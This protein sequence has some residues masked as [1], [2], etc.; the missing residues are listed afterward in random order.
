[1]QNFCSEN[2]KEIDH[3]GDLRVDGGTLFKGVDRIKLA[4][5]EVH[6]LGPVNTINTRNN[7]S[8]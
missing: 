2:L 4:Q 1:M 3:L 8:L 6:W 7:M 5:G